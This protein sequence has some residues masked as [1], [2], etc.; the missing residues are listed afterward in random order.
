MA[1]CLS[2]GTKYGGREQLQIIKQ[3]E[4]LL[5]G[6]REKADVRGWM[7]AAEATEG[8]NLSH[9][10]AT[11]SEQ[12]VQLTT[13]PREHQPDVLSRE[14][15]SSPTQDPVSKYKFILPS[16]YKP[17]PKAIQY[18]ELLDSMTWI[19]GQDIEGLQFYDEFLTA[20]EGETLMQI[21][22]EWQWDQEVPTRQ[23][24]KF[25]AH[26][27]YATKKLREGRPW[28]DNLEWLRTKLVECKIFDKTPDETMVNKTAPPQGFGAHIDD[29]NHFGGTVVVIGIG[30]AVNF[31]LWNQARTH[32]HTLRSKPRSMIVLSGPARYEYYHSISEGIDDEWRNHTF[33]RGI[34]I[35][36]TVRQLLKQHEWSQ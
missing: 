22:R 34:R 15:I 11:N 17:S 13:S 10:T 5:Q 32:Y 28:P 6:T 16:A 7:P 35:S 27:E 21:S 19:E 36:D 14:P 30:A 1:A 20:E 8:S 4:G 9:D 29:V 2:A 33:A 25:G 18:Q 3:E 24:A 31:V 23:T 26:Y 12:N